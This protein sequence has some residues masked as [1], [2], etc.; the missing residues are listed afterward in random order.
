MAM[1]NFNITN[2]KTETE[3]L[4]TL[5]RI[6]E[7]KLTKTAHTFDKY[8]E[9]SILEASLKS[10]T[11]YSEDTKLR[12]A[13][14]LI[15]VVLAANRNYNKVVEPNIKRI[16]KTDLSSFDDLSTLLKSKSKTEF[17]VFWGHKDEKKYNTLNYIL[18]SIE[19]LRKENPQIK[20]D[21]DLMKNWAV[22]ASI[23]NRRQDLI[24]KIPN[25]AIATFQHLR[26]TFGVDTVKPDLRV[27]DVLDFEFNTQR[28]SDENAI[29]AVEQIARIADLKTITIDQIF[30]KY[31]SGY[32]NQ[33]ANKLNTKQIAERLKQFGV[34]LDII[35]KATNLSTEQIKRL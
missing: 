3:I 12:P 8:G 32:Y 14:G 27:K 22:N 7:K 30:V 21:F 20:N 26:M 34:D 10:T 11:N 9:M 24:G 16:E 4:A 31:G 25:I 13:I 23:K 15:S 5:K 18:Q 2:Y 33:E 35:S 19:I 17:Y 28:L 6:G 1:K 29:K